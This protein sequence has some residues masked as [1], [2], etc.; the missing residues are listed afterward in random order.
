MKAKNIH[1]QETIVEK[2]LVIFELGSENFGIDIAS[3]EGINKM[4]DITKVPQA[5]SYVEGITNLRGSVLPV[6]DLQK[7]FAL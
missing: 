6:I 4:L 3:V 2:Q 7:R 5:P 1:K